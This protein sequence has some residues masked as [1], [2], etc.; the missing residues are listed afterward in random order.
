MIVLTNRAD[1]RRDYGERWE[2]QEKKMFCNE[3][4][5][6]WYHVRAWNATRV[7]TEHKLHSALTPP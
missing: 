5:V 1:D 3:K 4:E 7:S 2:R 6:L